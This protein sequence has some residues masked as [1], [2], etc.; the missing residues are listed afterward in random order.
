MSERPYE[1]GLESTKAIWRE[2]AL[3]HL[4][5]LREVILAATSHLDLWRSLLELLSDAGTTESRKM[6]IQS[7]YEYAWW[8]IAVSG[9]EDFAAEV[10]TYFYE[11][12]SAYSDFKKQVPPFVAPEQFKYLERYFR[13]RLTDKEFAAL[14]RM[15]SPSKIEKRAITQEVNVRYYQ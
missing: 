15:A 5:D 7:I 13:Y 9:N 4:P 1:C 14:A 3:K 10:G 6:E 8:C 11:D 2:L 12:L